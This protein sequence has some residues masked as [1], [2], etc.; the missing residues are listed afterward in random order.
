MNSSYRTQFHCLL[1]TS[2]PTEHSGPPEEGVGL[3]TREWEADAVLRPTV[4][5]NEGVEDDLVDLEADQIF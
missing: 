5:Q 1:G 4:A 2:F 3:S